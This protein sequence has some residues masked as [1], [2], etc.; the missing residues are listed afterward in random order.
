MS[1][2]R[3]EEGGWALVTAIVLMTL[4]M[5]TGL[6]TFAYVDTQQSES[7]KERT[8]ESAF[9]YAEAALNAQIFSLSREWPGVGAPASNSTYP[10]CDQTV[11]NVRCPSATTLAALFPSVDTGAGTTYAT[12]IRDN[13]DHELPG[14]PNFYSDALVAT[15]PAYDANGDGKLWVR[16][17]AQARARSARS[18]RWS[19]PRR[20]PR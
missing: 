4:M 7:R 3:G 13:I 2:W 12:P 8:R 15:A 20:S 10:A 5:A 19:T 9:N 6:T 1:R 14:A 16:A 11:S 17:E 18:S